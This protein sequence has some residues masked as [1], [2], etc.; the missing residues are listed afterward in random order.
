[1]NSP[2]TISAVRVGLALLLM[3]QVGAL[4]AAG[5][6]DSS[7][8]FADV[9]VIDGLGGPARE[10]QYVLVERGRISRVSDDPIPEDPGITVVDGRGRYLMPGLWDMHAHSFA[11]TTAMQLYLAAGVTGLR[12][13]GCAEGCAK[14]L[15]TIRADYLTGSGSY[16]RIFFSGPMLDGDSPYDDYPSH[17]QITLQTLAPALA[18]LQKLEVDFIKVRDFLSRDE[19]MALM[20]AGAAMN[21]PLAGHVPTSLSVNDAVRAGLSTVEHEGSLF[22]GLLLA[23]SSEEDD[24]RAEFLAMMRTATDSGDVPA[25]YAGA[26]SAALLDRIQNSYDPAKADALVAAFVES[27]AALVP[28][29]VVQSPKLRASDPVFNG[30]R[31]ADDEEFQELPA[32]LLKKWRQVAGTEVLEQPFSDK[33]RAAMARQ[34]DVLARLLTKMHQAGVPILAGTDASFPD[35]TPWI[36]PGYSLH[37]ELELLV[38]LGLSPTEAIASST[39]R[40]TQQMGL[41]DVGTVAPGMRA[42]LVLL[43]ENPAEDVSHTRAIERVWVN[44]QAVD[45][46]RLLRHVNERAADHEHYWE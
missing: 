29:L 42:D 30:R 33:D 31:K 34:Y 18:T 17:R 4:S 26:L 10:H 40:A 25:L 36:W 6:D 38:E 8:L 19:F 1:V 16:P 14:E 46:E 20:G 39:G 3:I 32:T 9:T 13:M 24:L 15:G 43:S 37:D 11:D 21:L 22:G 28:T 27:G 7:T 45:R 12:D 23:C 41:T 35:G 44:G 2:G 5:K